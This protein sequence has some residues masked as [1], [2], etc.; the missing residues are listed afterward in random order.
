MPQRN[1][2][3]IDNLENIRRFATESGATGVA[4]YDHEVDHTSDLVVLL[5][6]KVE[7]A[8]RTGAPGREWE[9]AEAVQAVIRDRALI[10]RSNGEGF[11]LGPR[12]N[13]ATG[14]RNWALEM[15]S[16]GELDHLEEFE[17]TARATTMWP[18]HLDQLYDR[19]LEILRRPIFF[20]Y[21]DI[22]PTAMPDLLQRLE[23]L[24]HNRVVHA[25]LSDEVHRSLPPPNLTP[26]PDPSS[27]RLPES[28]FDHLMQDD[29]LEDP[30]PDPPKPPENVFDRLLQEDL[31]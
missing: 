14:H 4:I 20:V 16:P 30:K 27:L 10:L 2:V 7:E 15:E 19:A 28:I 23:T 25:I 9:I 11:R 26:L 31:I 22:T 1:R 21:V 29:L 18:V 5:S 24:G 6:L 3:H 8:I 13:M 12:E 17:D